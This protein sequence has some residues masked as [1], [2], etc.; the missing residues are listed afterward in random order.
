MS[1]EKD[2]S[3]SRAESR[4]LADYNYSARRLAKLLQKYGLHS[5][6]QLIKGSILTAQRGLRD[7]R[8]QIEWAYVSYAGEARLKEMKKQY[9]EARAKEAEQ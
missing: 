3:L 9:K 7:V 1:G 6:A 8:D 5:H 2:F 4:T